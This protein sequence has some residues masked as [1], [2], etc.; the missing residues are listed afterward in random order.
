MPPS[1]CRIFTG[2]V[3]CLIAASSLVCDSTAVEGQRQEKLIDILQ[4]L[5]LSIAEILN[6]LGPN[7]LSGGKSSSSSSSS[8][9]SSISS[10]KANGE[11]TLSRDLPGRALG[12]SNSDHGGSSKETGLGS[13][14][15]TPPGSSVGSRGGS[16]SVGGSTPSSSSSSSSSGIPKKYGTGKQFRVSP[17]G[18]F[19]CHR[20]TRPVSLER[21]IITEARSASRS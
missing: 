4:N 3:V 5:Q 6:T 2:I 15:D 18:I 16:S 8:S 12:R 14:L 19:N 17:R 11:R 10:P 1:K 9:G 13:S 20:V 7:A 21:A